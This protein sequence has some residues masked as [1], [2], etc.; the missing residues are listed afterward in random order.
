[1]L[2]YREQLIQPYR[3]LFLNKSFELNSHAHARV[4]GDGSGHYRDLSV[5]GFNVE[6]YSCVNGQR[7]KSV[8]VTT[9]DR[10]VGERAPISE[11]SILRAHLNS[12]VAGE[13]RVPPLHFVNCWH[14][15]SVLTILKPIVPPNYSGQRVTLAHGDN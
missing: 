14:T 1:M 15:D 13:T 9:A 8:N 3:A 11:F 5:S 7:R 6:D 2:Q 4:E 10:Y 12:C